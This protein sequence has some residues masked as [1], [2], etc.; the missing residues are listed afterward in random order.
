MFTKVLGFWAIPVEDL[1]YYPSECSTILRGFLQLFARIE[2]GEHPV[3]PAIQGSKDQNPRKLSFWQQ[4]SFSFSGISGIL[5]WPNAIWRHLPSP[6]SVAQGDGFVQTTLP[7]L[8]PRSRAGPRGR[9]S[10]VSGRVRN[11]EPAR[12][13]QAKVEHVMEHGGWGCSRGLWMSLWLFLRLLGVCKGCGR[14]ISCMG[15]LKIRGP[16]YDLYSYPNELH[17][18]LLNP[19][20]Y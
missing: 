7:V 8:V 19:I 16:L 5:F 13:C 12:C 2:C 20:N 14:G 15:R 18:T 3:S 11:P 1:T 10:F 9:S 6:R 4:V 17:K